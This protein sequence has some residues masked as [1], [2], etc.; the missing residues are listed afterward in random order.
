[1]IGN[2]GRDMHSERMPAMARKYTAGHMGNLSG[3]P[4][5]I[6]AKPPISSGNPKSGNPDM[7]V[8]R[9]FVNGFESEM[10]CKRQSK[11]RRKTCP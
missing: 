9:D 5:W 10:A 1:M 6:Q 3:A 7:E 11:P 2:D 4:L 8:S